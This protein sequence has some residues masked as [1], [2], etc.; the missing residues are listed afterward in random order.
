MAA[1]SSLAEYMV[2][3]ALIGSTDRHHDSWGLLVQK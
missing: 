1:K 3:D 2:L